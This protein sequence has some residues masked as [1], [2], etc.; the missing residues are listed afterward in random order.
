MHKIIPFLQ[1]I[2]GFLVFGCFGGIEN[3]TMTIPV[4]IITIAIACIS[5]Y[6]LHVIDTKLKTK[7]TKTVRRVRTTAT[8]NRAA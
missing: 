2:M 1:T 3:D 6:A 7:R 4:A 8:A 5:I